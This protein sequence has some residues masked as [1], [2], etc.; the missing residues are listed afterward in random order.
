MDYDGNVICERKNM[1]E[2]S[3]EI[4]WSDSK[5]VLLQNIEKETY[6]RIKKNCLSKKISARCICI[7][8]CKFVFVSILSNG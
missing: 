5:Q 3:P 8:N 6:Q 4:I 1:T 7:I 2:N